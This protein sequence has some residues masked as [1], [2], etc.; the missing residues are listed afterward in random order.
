MELSKPYSNSTKYDAIKENATENVLADCF[1][2]TENTDYTHACMGNIDKLAP[3][4]RN[5]VITHP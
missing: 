1:F 2:I 5:L 3:M 4:Y